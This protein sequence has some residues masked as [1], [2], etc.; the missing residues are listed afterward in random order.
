MRAGI[1]REPQLS[2]RRKQKRNA[3]RKSAIAGKAGSMIASYCSRFVSNISRLRAGDLNSRNGRQEKEERMEDGQNV[4][5]F[6]EPTNLATVGV[7]KLSLFF[8]DNSNS[9][10]TDFS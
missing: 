7:I 1:P 6:D 4:I 10:S 8:H 5:R 2:P 3:T 9:M